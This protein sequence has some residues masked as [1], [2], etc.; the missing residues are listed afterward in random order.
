MGLKYFYI[1]SN[2]KHTQ[3]FWKQVEQQ[4]EFNKQLAF[5][6]QLSERQHNNVCSNLI[7]GTARLT[8]TTAQIYQYC[9]KYQIVPE[10]KD[11]RISIKGELAKQQSLDFEKTIDYSKFKD[12]EDVKLDGKKGW[13]LLNDEDLKIVTVEFEDGEIEDY[14]Y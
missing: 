2:N 12:G 6:Q 1:M 5:V 8:V 9:Q 14:K 11:G 4:E 3:A 7:K 13:V 10:G